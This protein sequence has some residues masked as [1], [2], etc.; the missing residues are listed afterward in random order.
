MFTD[1]KTW[2]TE[3]YGEPLFRVPVQIAT[4]CPHGRCIFCSE[5]GAKA[6][7]ITNQ[8]TPLEQIEA[9]V[10]FS[11]RRYR[12]QKMMLYIQAF[13]TDLTDPVQQ[14]KIIECLKAYS[15]EAVS[16]GMRPD[17]LSNSA[18]DFL[19]SL[20]Q[21]VWIEL[22][23]QSMNDGTLERIHRG[24]DAACSKAAIQT[25]AANGIFVAAH[26]MIGLPGETAAEWNATA[27]ALAALPVSGMKIHNLHV[28]KGT[29]LAAQFEAAPF[30]VLSHW[31][32]AEALM[33]FLRRTPASVPVMRI[34]TDT[35][36]EEL[37]APVWHLE[38]GQFLDYVKQQMLMREIRQ[39][40]LVRKNGVMDD[41]I[42]GEESS[43]TIHL[44]NN[45]LIQQSSNPV[46]TGDGSITFFSDDWKE[47]YHTKTGARLEAENKFVAPSALTERL[48]R[49]NVQLLDVCFGLGNNSL[50]AASAARGSGSRL[51]ITALEMDRRIVRAAAAHF[52]PLESDPVDWKNILRRL[53]EDGQSSIVNCQFSMHWGD[54]RRLV[55]N[56]PAEGF[57]IIFHDPFSSQHCPELWTVEFFQQLF[58][59]MKAD[60]ILLTY[61]SALP[62]RGALM[63]AGFVLGE[64]VP[65]HSMGS[66]TAAAKRESGLAAF[67]RIERTDTRRSLPYRDPFL[68]DTSKAILRRRQEQIEQPRR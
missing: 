41:W 5:S 21:E 63:E 60:G 45:P 34:S 15:F 59:V 46:L 12:A 38:K 50:A 36:E 64:T 19:K 1:Y 66:G 40:D 61:S 48:R 67:R 42:N 65:G 26:V 43:S 28:V 32:Y 47:H 56:L 7:Q 33:E 18:I 31:D 13:T 29:A 4:A 17:C 10:R 30:P 9:A 53:L 55:Q 3:R 62:V 51:N 14:N 8:Q 27:D 22:G 23:V 49:G 57:D 68:C 54:A 25:L 24:H 44:S 20:K 16:I 35:P 6:Q 39:G 37:V 2:S 58:R 11:K 52:I